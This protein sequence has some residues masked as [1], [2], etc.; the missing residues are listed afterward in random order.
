MKI[1]DCVA[2]STGSRD[3]VFSD[4]LS[5][6][7]CALAGGTMEAEYLATIQKYVAGEKGKGPVDPLAAAFGRLVEIMTDIREDIIGDLFQG[8]IT[9][10]EHAEYFSVDRHLIMLRIWRDLRWCNCVRR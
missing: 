4:F 8:G 1:L 5:M 9:Y 7:V 3:Q 2:T 10:G 6:A